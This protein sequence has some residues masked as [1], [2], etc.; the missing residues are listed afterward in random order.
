MLFVRS[1]WNSLSQNFSGDDEFAVS[2]G[3]KLPYWLITLLVAAVHLAS[4]TFDHLLIS[5]GDHAILAIPESGLDFVAIIVFG[6]RC[7]PI[8]LPA[9]F[10]TALWLHVPWGS[11]LGVAVASVL[12]SLLAACLFRQIA[13][14]RRALGEF[15]DLIGIVVAGTLTPAVSTGL[16]TLCLL[17]GTR[18]PRVA[19]EALLSRWW[20][21]ETL[22]ILTFGPVLLIF[23]RLWIARSKPVGRRHLVKFVTCIFC[24]S[25][26]CYYILFRVGESGLVFAV[27][28][29]ILVATAWLGPVAARLS[30]LTVAIAAIG[31]T[32]LGLGGF[33]G[34]SLGTNRQNLDLFLAAVSLTGLSLGSFRAAGHLRL[35][36][37]VLLAGWAL[38]GWL[39]VSLERDRINYDEARFDKVITSVESRLNSRF[40]T[41]DDALRSAAG[42]LAASGPI[43]PKTW[44]IYVSRSGLLERYPG[45]AIISVV[46]AVADRDLDTFVRAHRKGQWPD[47]TVRPISWL[48]RIPE[49][50]D[51]HLL[52]VC[53]EPAAAAIRA[54]GGDLAGDPARRE[55]AEQSRDFGT[56]VLTRST[57]LGGDSGKGLQLFVPVYREGAPVSTLSER[58]QA[59]IA[60]VTV[61]FRAEPFFRSALAELV[62]MLGLRVYDG[63]RP[64]PSARFFSSGPERGSGS[65]AERTTHLTLGRNNWTLT[66]SR[67]PSFPFLS[68]TPSAWAA[69]CTALLS[70]LSACLITTLQSTK[71]RASI[72]AAEQTAELKASEARKTAIMDSALDPIITINGAGCVTEF[73]PAAERTF[74][75]RRDQVLGQE[76]AETIIPQTMRE[77]HR[78]GLARVL[79][80]GEETLLGKRIEMTALRADGTEFPVELAVNRV[81]H[82]GSPIF[83]AYLRD[84]S[85]RKRIEERLNI[86]SSAVE[87]SPVSVIITTLDGR[88]EYVN[89][90]L[91]RVTGY[92]L[93]ELKGHDSRILATSDTPPEVFTEILENLQGRGSWQ[94]V[95]QIR[96]KNG[97]SLWASNSML[98]IHDSSGRPTH[99][100]TVA[101]DITE[102]VEMETAL[103]A[104]EERFRIAAKNSGDVIYEWDFRSGRTQIF[105][106]HRRRFGIAPHEHP[107]TSDGYNELIHPD[108]FDRVQA[109]V[110]RH[111][112]SGVPFSEEYRLKLPNGEI[113]YLTDDGS[114]V[115]DS[116]GKPYKWIGVLRDVTDQK[117]A[118]QKVSQLAAIVECADA[119]IVSTDLLGQV[120]TWNGGAERI[121]GYAAGEML[122]QSI[123]TIIPTDRLEEFAGMMEKLKQGQTVDHAETKRLTK[124]GTAIDVLV[125]ISPI[126]DHKGSVLGTAGI[127]WDVTPIKRLETQLAQAQ[128]LESIGQLASGI[129][130]EINTP[131]QY[132]GDNARFLEDAFR[133]LVSFAELRR[134]G[135]I[136]GSESLPPD[137]GITP[138][139]I[140]EGVLDYL[141]GE[142]P[143]SIG[144]LIEGV[145]QVARIVRAMKEFSHPGPVE[146]MPVDINRSIESTIVVSRNEWK[147]VADVTTDLWP[148]LPPVPCVAG[149]LNQ[150]V[151]NLIVNAAHAI[152]D[153]VKDSG[154]KGTIR[155]STHQ[156][157]SAVEIRISDTGGGIPPAIQTKIFDPFFTTKP[158]GKGSGQGLA[159]AHSVIVQ[160]HKG[161]LTF[162]SEAG[163]GTTFIIQLPLV[164]ELE[165]A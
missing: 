75:Y 103:K 48:G 56:A 89:D 19:W 148:D 110:Q 99:R 45:T 95:L 65:R 154:R 123:A 115:K 160:K 40:T 106:G 150:A 58:R 102:R 134:D 165:A 142:I 30:A 46:Q 140:E 47:F 33:V 41:Y 114:A 66:W 69:G 44:Q 118:E 159:I 9:Y 109:A 78:R 128:K 104:S 94:G 77:A 138:Q 153:V 96:K 1:A 141:R 125:T 50:T 60:W 21:A 49:V 57:I 143:K 36:G 108:D 101:L 161:V 122:G 88:I 116:E 162:Q 26:A 112:T 98:L 12:Q 71:K 23:A 35:P 158:V 93:E 51:E 149:E 4:A 31:A 132:I 83:T 155:I 113:R 61:V 11:S 136:S 22:G 131:I 124:S 27:L 117:I 62:P 144:Q 133:D 146:K 20:L 8:L 119:A 64:V 80:S 90:R 29:V 52:I 147:Y 24:V 37:T 139:M 120:L 137:R 2:P 38:S 151:L 91:T 126:R 42:F 85:E 81:N 10:A 86:L 3:R 87:Q 84:L 74:G 18:L 70:L 39:Y 43:T 164:G 76:L 54:I 82:E 14:W 28:A 111:L 6:P 156:L 152:A 92:T 163:H 34:Q 68:R 79:E 13:A 17:V 5:S 16:G 53:A 73:N 67:L 32:H 105:G 25:I 15:V 157:D 72:L 97:E 63:E 127:A 55:A 145:D 121:Y 130:H 129:A 107:T 135:D 7:W 100:L 59:L